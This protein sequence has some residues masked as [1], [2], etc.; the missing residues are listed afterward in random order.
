MIGQNASAI[1]DDR[2]PLLLKERLNTADL[3]GVPYRILIGR[4]DVENDTAELRF[5]QNSEPAQTLSVN[6][7]GTRLN[8]LL[9]N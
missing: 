9:R 3:L 8:S 5:R 1:L 7:I 4:R 6:D 2:Y